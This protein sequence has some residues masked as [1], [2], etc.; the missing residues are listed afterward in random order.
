M[1]TN[2]PVVRCLDMGDH[3]FSGSRCV[4]LQ[5]GGKDRRVTNG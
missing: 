3:R 5:D 4:A 1:E 2:D